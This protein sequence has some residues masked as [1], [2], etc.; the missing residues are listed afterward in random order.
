M[1][2]FLN[3]N[4]VYNVLGRLLHSIYFISST[5]VYFPLIRARIGFYVFLFICLLLLRAHDEP[6]VR[7][8]CDL[9]AKFIIFI[10]VHPYLEI[11]LFYPAIDVDN[12]FIPSARL[13]ERSHRFIF[14][15]NIGQ[16]IKL[17]QL[18]WK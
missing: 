17:Q 9:F 12:L 1:A 4:S 7:L 18:T 13:T 3:S 6:I 8:R 14:N 5:F 10:F 15:S 2:V 16:I 11:L